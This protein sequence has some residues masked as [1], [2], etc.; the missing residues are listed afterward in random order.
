MEKMFLFP[1]YI[2][3]GNASE[4]GESGRGGLWQLHLHRQESQGKRHRRHHA[5]RFVLIG[6]G[7]DVQRA[8]ERTARGGE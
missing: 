4:R 5:D 7:L 2:A 1:S 3:G 8:C 6:G